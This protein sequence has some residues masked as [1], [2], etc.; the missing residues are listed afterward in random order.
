MTIKE[1]ALDKAV[2]TKEAL[3][4]GATDFASKAN[5]SKDVSNTQAFVNVVKHAWK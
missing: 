1:N 4:K 5:D 2:A 3:S